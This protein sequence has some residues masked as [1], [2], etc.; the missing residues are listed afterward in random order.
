MRRLAGRTM[1]LWDSR[2]S[3]W[4][5][6]PDF[7]SKQDE[8]IR[9]ANIIS[10]APEFQILGNR[11]ISLSKFFD[12]DGQSRFES[13]LAESLNI[14]KSEWIKFDTHLKQYRGPYR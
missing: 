7:R 8:M 13:R 9:M 5:F 6:F 4:T 1:E 10:N 14:Y 11:S 12:D 3:H 2:H